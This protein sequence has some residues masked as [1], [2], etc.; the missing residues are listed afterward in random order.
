MVYAAQLKTFSLHFPEY[1][2]QMFPYLQPITFF[3][4]QSIFTVVKQIFES[5]IQS[6]SF[7]ARVKNLL[8]EIESLPHAQVGHMFWLIDQKKVALYEC[9]INKWL[10]MHN[11][12]MHVS[13]P[14]CV[15]TLTLA[16]L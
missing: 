10:T 15:K 2:P 11:G 7:F 1:L 3:K 14:F 8:T 4:G 16:P 13:M 5:E 12:Y 9:D 6:F